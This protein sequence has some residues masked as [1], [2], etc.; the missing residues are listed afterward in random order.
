MEMKLKKFVLSGTGCMHVLFCM[1]G[2]WGHCGL[3]K[4]V[5]AKIMK[6]MNSILKFQCVYVIYMLG[7]QIDD[8][9][10]RN[11]ALDKEFKNCQQHY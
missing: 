6:A 10:L 4:Y 2:C 1:Q 11:G 9:M 3:E 7:L 8:S 5:I